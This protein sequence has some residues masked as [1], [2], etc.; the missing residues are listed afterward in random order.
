MK[1]VHTAQQKLKEFHLPF[2]F[3]IDICSSLTEFSNI[4]A[5][6]KTEQCHYC[7]ILH[8]SDECKGLVICIKTKNH[9]VTIRFSPFSLYCCL[10]TVFDVGSLFQTQKQN[11]M[12]NRI[13]SGQESLMSIYPE[14]G[15]YATAMVRNK[16]HCSRC[17]FGVDRMERPTV[18]WYWSHSS[19][20]QMQTGSP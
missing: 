3:V 20:R 7:D 6:L 1:S 2:H 15:V 14:Q 10:Y 19:G 17:I 12:H 8:L 9:G 11:I 18:I 13:N 4:K 5:R 16:D